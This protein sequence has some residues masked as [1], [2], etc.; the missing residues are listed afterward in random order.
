MNTKRPGFMLYLTNMAMFNFCTDEQAGKLIK[1]CF[2]YVATDE[3]P[4]HCLR[5][6]NDYGEQV[7][8]EDDKIMDAYFAILQSALDQD[9][10]RYEEIQQERIKAGRK[11]GQVS[12]ERR[13]KNSFDSD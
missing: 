7:E 4:Y 11:G 1:A 5:S 13:K 9:A 6:K 3:Y 8:S 10:K 2:H 12:G